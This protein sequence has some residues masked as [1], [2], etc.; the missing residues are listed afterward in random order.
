VSRLAWGRHFLVCPPDHFTVAYEINPYMHRQV[1]P[2]QDRAKQQFEGL[3][4]SLRAAGAS[5]E[6]L[7]PVDGLPDL[8]FTAN[9]G[10]VDGNRFVPSRFLH[11]ERQGETPVDEA[12]F[13]SHG[14]EI[15]ELEGDD[16]FEG[17]GDALPFGLDLTDEGVV[18]HPVLVSGYRTRSSVT[19]HAALSEVLG[20]PVRSVELTDDRYYHL[21]LV[22]C[23]LDSR[24][25]LVAPQGLD[26][27]GIKVLEQL[28][29][30]PIWLEEDE[31]ESFS[32]NSVVIDQTVVMPACTPRLGRIL[33]GA[34]FDV[35]VT[36]VDEFLKAGGGC[37][38]LTLALDVRLNV[39]PIVQSGS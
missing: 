4:A 31:A 27:F 5:V 1:H 18:P 39:D 20:V 23:P 19:A 30:E 3:V 9:A 33:G 16:A 10:I 36:P 29:P 28:V 8:V 15:V 6:L 14:F 22:F 13:A 21:D 2:D 35:V 25:A 37:R 32:A 34:G 17:A 24:R 11:A 26:R 12:W 7:E 38:C